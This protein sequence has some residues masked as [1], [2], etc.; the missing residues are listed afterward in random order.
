VTTD[1]A[2]ILIVDDES[3]NR[4]LLETLLQP[5][6]YQTRCAA[7][8]DD[9]LASMA[10]LP[11]DLILLD[12]M[13]PGMDG[14]Q[15]AK[16][17]KANPVTASIPIIMV[18]ANIDRDARLA[19]LNA[20]A[21]EFLTKPIDRAELWYRVR[22]LLRLKTLN[23]VLQNQSVLLEDLVQT[24]TADLHRLAHYDPLTDLPNRALLLERLKKTLDSAQEHGWSVAVMFVD[25]DGLK[26]VNDTLGHALGDELLAQLS[27]RLVDCV[28]L[29]D[30]VGRL[31]GD[32]FAIV[33]AM[34]DGQQDAALLANHIQAALREPFKLSDR[35]VVVTASLGIAVYPEDS[36]DPET[37][38]RYAD[39]AMYRAKQ[40]GRD[41]FRFFTAQM[42][43]DVVARRDL[44]AALRQA[45]EQDE[46]VLHYQPKV[47]LEHGGIVGLEALLRWQRPEH[48]LVSPSDFIAVL[49]ETGLIVDVGRWVI[50]TAC[51]Q[52]A[53]WM[54]SGVGPVQVSVN[55]SGRQFVEGDLQ[56]DV[57]T[58][59]DDNVISADLIELELTESSL[60]ENTERT[61][62]ALQSLKRRGVTISIDDFG[63]GYSSLAYLS[64]FPIDKLKI[65]IDFIRE[66]TTKADD[67]VIAL[68]IIRLAHSLNLEVIAEGVET[69]AQLAYLQYHG[70]DQVQGYYFSRPLPVREL[71]PLLRADTRSPKTNGGPHGPF[72]ARLLREMSPQAV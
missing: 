55:V 72:E 68:T 38:I 28:R 54:S 24:R 18:T 41:T 51:R 34:E 45:I 4:K 13:M 43:I 63:T 3:H 44:E 8:G 19:G 39:T 12:V 20:G 9:A 35:E 62:A 10:E 48:G 17:I 69:A 53:R 23:D 56:H 33:L 46:F 60:M 31:G 27:E 57:I 7:N 49:E 50:V 29:R 58:A 21:E 5:E 42:N 36:A 67:A 22:N 1:N 61:I 2:T 25:V 14:Y 40:A 15:V 52:V 70:C 11:P 32:E 71:E 6:G 64:R 37:L 16:C 66:I 30:T 47:E 65:D 59:I 26:R